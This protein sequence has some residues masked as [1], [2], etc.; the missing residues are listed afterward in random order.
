MAMLSLSV[1]DTAVCLAIND[2][3]DLLKQ[4]LAADLP[5]A[6]SC[7]NGNCGR[8]DCR[9]ESGEVVL[10]NGGKLSA[11]ALI[12]LC[13]S[14]A[15][16]DLCIDQLPLTSIAQHWRCE[17]LNPIQLQ[18]PAGRQTPPKYGDIVALLLTDAVLINSVTAIDGRIITLRDHC[19]EIEQHK[20][21][22]GGIGLLN[23]DR[24]HSG[25]FALWRSNPNSQTLLWQGINQATGLAARAAYQRAGMPGSYQ[26][27]QLNPH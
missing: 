21:K 16:S 9:L 27:R 11:P 17:G 14:H 22:R 26:L 12:A 19:N 10:R 4:C 24:E 25:D 2:R 15:R 20:R 8:C 13:I 5:V 7:R 6:R 1:A 3:D 18:L 23:I